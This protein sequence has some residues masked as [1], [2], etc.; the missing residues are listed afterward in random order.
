MTALSAAMFPRRSSYFICSR[1]SARSF[2]AHW[3]LMDFARY[4]AA[5]S[6]K[7][8]SKSGVISAATSGASSSVTKRR[9]T[10]S[11]HTS[12][13]DLPPWRMPRR[14]EKCQRLSAC[15]KQAPRETPNEHQKQHTQTQP[16]RH[17]SLLCQPGIL[18][19]NNFFG[20]NQFDCG[21]SS[22]RAIQHCNRA[23]VSRFE[24]VAHSPRRCFGIPA[25]QRRNDQ[26][27]LIQSGFGL[28]IA[29]HHH[30]AAAVKLRL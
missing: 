29:R 16:T 20:V 6:S 5:V 21:V 26:A 1:N 3:M 28:A 2:F 24:M 8:I 23:A 30:V 12:G 15:L 13:G 18:G 27:M 4:P 25:L 9:E 11:V 22:A 7:V 14:N 19:G 10:G 17:T